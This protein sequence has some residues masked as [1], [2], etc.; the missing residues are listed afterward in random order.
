MHPVRPDEAGELHVVVDGKQGAGGFTYLFEFFRE[1]DQP[2][3]RNL[4]VSQLDD[5]YSTADGSLHAG[6]E[7]RARVRD[8]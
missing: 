4:L 3:P 7:V 5:V 8:Q 1:R 2:F 6:D